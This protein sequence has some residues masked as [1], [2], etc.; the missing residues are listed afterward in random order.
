MDACDL[1]DHVA[2]QVA[3]LH[4]VVHATK[5]GRDHVAAIVS[6]R[7]RETPQVREQAGTARS[8]GPRAFFVIDEGE[9]LIAGDALRIRG[10]VAPSIRRLDR[11]SKPLARELGLVLALAFKVVEELEKHH[12][13]EHRQPVKVAVEP[14]VLAHDV[15]R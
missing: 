7:A 2:E 5:D 3:A 11:R 10:P 9:Q 1:V 4:P 15:T 6:V 8:V 13:G 14:L 12:P